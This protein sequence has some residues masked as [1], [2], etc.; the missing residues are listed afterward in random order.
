[1]ETAVGRRK[2]PAICFLLLTYLISTRAFAAKTAGEGRNAVA[3]C[4]PMAP[5]NGCR[6]SSMRRG[7]SAAAP[8]TRRQHP[9][10]MSLARAPLQRNAGGSP[11]FERT[12]VGA[13]AE[14]RHGSRGAFCRLGASARSS[15][16]G[17][18]AASFPG[19]AAVTDAAASAS[20]AGASVDAAEP[21]SAAAG[22]P[23]LSI[24][25]GREQIQR[26]Q[27]QVCELPEDTA[28]EGRFLMMAALVGVI[29]G[30]AGE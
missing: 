19:V 16:E 22:P 3:L 30:T 4:L 13:T 10:A 25:W 1:M 11:L 26:L 9:T 29:T 2:A 6:S 23:F 21:A 17:P 18:A 15:T 28:E 7:H 8:S 14:R 24:R 20:P 12:R 5:R 27:R